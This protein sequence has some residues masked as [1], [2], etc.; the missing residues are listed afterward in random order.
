MKE[1]ELNKKF[2]LSD[3]EME[4]RAAEYESGN[5]DVTQHGKIHVGRPTKFSEPMESITFREPASV[6]ISI[7]RRAEQKGFTKSEY[8]REL[9]RQDLAK[10]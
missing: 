10:V 2:G 3:G 4:R 7:E 8:I 9:I 6:I 1:M 5:W